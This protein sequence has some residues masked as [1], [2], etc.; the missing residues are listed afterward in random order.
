MPVG[1]YKLTS[2]IDV[3]TQAFIFH[4]DCV[5]RRGEAHFG[6]PAVNFNVLGSVLNFTSVTN[7]LTA[8]TPG[9]IGRI[10]DIGLVGPGSGHTSGI[11]FNIPFVDLYNVS[12]NN[13]W[14]GVNLATN[15]TQLPA[16]TVAETVMG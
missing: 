6:D 16:W 2:S 13:F 9:I 8:N 15:D 12:V 14:I 7:G 11:F 3:G 1:Q 5:Y 10:Q 4:G